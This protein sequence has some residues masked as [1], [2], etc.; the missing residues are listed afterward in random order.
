MGAFLE[1]LQEPILIRGVLGPHELFHVTVLI[2]LSL[3]WKFI[4]NIARVSHVSIEH[5]EKF[6]MCKQP[7]G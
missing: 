1:F 3:H 5:Q 6:E 4:Y 7:D 2:G